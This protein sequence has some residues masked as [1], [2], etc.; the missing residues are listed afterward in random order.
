M[1]PLSP[2]TTARWKYI[3]QN[4]V[5]QHTLTL[6]LTNDSVTADA[7][8][9]MQALMSNIG[10]SCS[11]S[12]IT[13]LEHAPASSDI[14]NPVAD[15][16]LVGDSFGSGAAIKQYNATSITFVGRGSDA[17][18][19]RMSLFG[20]KADLSEFRITAAESPDVATFINATLNAIATPLLTI[21][22]TAPV[23][24][25]YADIKANDHWV[26]KSR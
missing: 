21:S 1:A 18:R 10:I 2:S 24:K 19:A 4:A 20:W 6:R 25:L 13:G 15:S 8:A 12:T 7:D 9:I 22:G 16:D 23:W 3:Y 5:A 14:F 26:D 11:E 17:R